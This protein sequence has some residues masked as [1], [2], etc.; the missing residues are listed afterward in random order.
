MK[1]LFPAQTRMLSSQQS[2]Q[3]MYIRKNRVPV[4]YNS[5]KLL[6]RGAKSS[7]SKLHSNHHDQISDLKPESSESN[8]R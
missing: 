6:E 7:E 5:N 3:M 1:I 8:T 4:L 2:T